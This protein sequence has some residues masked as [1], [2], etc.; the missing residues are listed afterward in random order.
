MRNT[1]LFSQKLINRFNAAAWRDS[2]TGHIFLLPREVKQAGKKG[3]PD[4][5]TL[6]LIEINNEGKVIHERVVWRPKN[7]ELHLEDPRAIVLPDKTVILGMTAV[8][9]KDNE[10]LPYPAIMTLNSS[11]WKQDLPEPQVFTEF[12]PGKNLTPIDENT[13]FFRKD[14]EHNSHKLYVLV[15]NQGKIDIAGELQFSEDIPW[16]E[17]RIGTTMPP[18][19]VNENEA[20]MLVHGITIKNNKY[21]YSLG[22]S[23]L[24]KTNGTYKVE[25][26]PV[27]ILTPDDFMSEGKSII[28]ELHPEARR[29]VYSCGGV[30]HSD[31]NEDKLTLFTNV[32]DTQTVEVPFSLTQLKSGFWT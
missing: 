9:K 15:Q 25:I 22:R 3:E 17:W 21:V 13:F 19:W 4:K 32:G 14:G 11:D 10:Y 6:V 24:F 2:E 26:D 29:V 23:K 7:D 30:I 20:L 28:D 1:Y 16:A 31:T 8:L 5:G 12:G 18:V 27:P